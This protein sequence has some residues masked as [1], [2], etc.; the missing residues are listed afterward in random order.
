MLDPRDRQ[1]LLEALRPPEG[2]AFDRAIGTTFSLEPTALLAAPLAFAAFDGGL[3]GCAPHDDSLALLEAVRRNA[4]HVSLFCQAGRIALPGKYRSLLTY[5]ERSVVEVVPPRAEFAFH[6][7]VWLVRYRGA[8]DSLTYR[9][10]CL[11]RNLTFD[12]SW[13]TV[14]S[15]EGEL[16]RRNNAFAVNHPLGDFIAALPRLAVR[17]VPQRVV[18]DVELMQ[19]EVRRVRFTAPEGFEGFGFVALGLDARK[20]WSFPVGNTKGLVVSP[21][22]SAETLQHLPDCRD[23]LTLVSRLEALEDLPAQ[24]RERFA[25]CYALSEMAEP[26]PT[27]DSEVSEPSADGGGARPAAAPLSGLHAKLFVFDQGW[28]AKLWSGSANAT[29]NPVDLEQREGRVHRY[30]G[31][32]VRKNVAQRYGLA[33]TID[34]PDEPVADPWDVL[35]ERA[36]K[37]RGEGLSDLVPFWIYPIEAGAQI[38]RYVPAL[39]LSRESARLADLLRS[40]VVYRAAIGQPRQQDLVDYLLKHLPPDEVAEVVDQLRIDLSPPAQE[41]D[42]RL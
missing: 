16:A 32:A 18:R 27:A 6:P 20:T 24:A 35:F 40:L 14:L 33:S 7:K 5:L 21:F 2:H 34:G 4:G 37:D 19:D 23:G 39:P 8:E 11:T 3:E 13:D 12:R 15:L 9:L 10:L 26:E 38:E 25:A 42:R 31:H 28:T 36:R 1:L 30:K 17:D 22:L 41:R 29:S